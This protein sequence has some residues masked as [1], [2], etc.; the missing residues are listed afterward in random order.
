M[1]LFIALPCH[2]GIV[3]EKTTMGL[4]N[5][6]KLLVR[7]NIS[8]GLLTQA[9][10]SL[11]TQGRSK[12]ANFFINNTDHEYILFLDSDIGFKA[13]DVLKLLN[14]KVDIV[15]ATYP[16]KT[17]PIRYCVNAVQPEQKRGDL[18]KIEGNGMGF[19]LIHRNVFGKIA[20]NYPELKYIPAD[21]SNFSISQEENNNSYHFFMEHK[22]ENKFLSEDKSFFYRASMVGYDI[23]LDTT[24]RL[25]HL[26]SHIFGE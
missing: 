4:F 16:M 2:G 13:E 21:N 14:H 24:I 20:Q 25:Q 10:S 8:H 15:S 6:G 12:C 11:I 7:N 23:W 18:L 5:L 1:S 26:G 19:T 3:T 9:N 17:I 22:K